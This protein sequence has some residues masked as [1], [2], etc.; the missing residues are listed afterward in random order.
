MAI[1]EFDV[2]ALTK[3][4]KAKHLG[5][6]PRQ[7]ATTKDSAPDVFVRSFGKNEA[8]KDALFSHPA[9]SDALLKTHAKRLVKAIKEERP[10]IANTILA[11]TRAAQTPNKML[12]PAVLH[13]AGSPNAQAFKQ[14]FIPPVINSP[15]IREKALIVAARN[16]NPKAFEM[17][18]TPPVT[19]VRGALRNALIAGSHN[20]NPKAFNR[21]LTTPAIIDPRALI[22]SLFP[23]MVNPNPKVFESL[24]RTPIMNHPPTLLVELLGAVQ[25]KNPERLKRAL[26]TPVIND[27]GMLETAFGAAAHN[28]NPKI[29]EMVAKTSFINNP[30]VFEEVLIFFAKDFDPES[31]ELHFNHENKLTIVKKLNPK[32]LEILFKVPYIQKWLQENSRHLSKDMVTLLRARKEKENIQT[33]ERRQHSRTQQSNRAIAMPGAWRFHE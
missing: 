9:V 27:P 7:K 24:R 16:T 15:S 2:K 1:G 3:A 19:Y 4:L 30:A 5:P 26:R 33:L 17:L 28:P 11:G 13:A 31:S 21:L 12:L 22:T 10:E 6:L 8:L 32:A 23:A 25:V 29:L 14:L 18:Y 20:P